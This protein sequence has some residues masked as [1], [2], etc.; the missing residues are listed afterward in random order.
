MDKEVL[1]KCGNCCHS[2]PFVMCGAAIGY[3]EY[4]EGPTGNPVGRAANKEGKCPDY[5]AKVE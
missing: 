3:N 1:R 2:L 4:M 5:K